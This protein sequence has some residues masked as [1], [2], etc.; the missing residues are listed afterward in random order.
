MA[1]LKKNPESKVTL[2][3]LLV[4]KRHEKP[5]KEFWSEFDRELKRKTLQKLAHQATTA[6][7]IFGLLRKASAVMMP[8][9]ALAAAVMA[10][11]VTGST[12]LVTEKGSLGQPEYAASAEVS[13]ASVANAD[14]I[15]IASVSDR[16]EAQAMAVADG[17]AQFVMDAF[18]ANDSTP[19]FRKV[20]ALES[21]QSIGSNSARYVADHLIGGA[22][23]GANVSATL[24]HF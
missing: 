5:S 20:R 13:R 23:A 10:F 12:V 24:A 9:G 2:E 22:T 4:L 16:S 14:F 6:E 7:R 15:T 17:R 11:Y 21:F 1:N 3:A 18:E 8:A 19:N